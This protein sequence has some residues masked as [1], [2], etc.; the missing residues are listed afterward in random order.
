MSEPAPC[1]PSANLSG[2]IDPANYLEFSAGWRDGAIRCA[3]TPAPIE[4]IEDLALLL[5][6]SALVGRTNPPA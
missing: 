5:D 1:P 6:S 4:V 3:T 2:I